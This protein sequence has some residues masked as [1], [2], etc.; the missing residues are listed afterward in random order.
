[1]TAHKAGARYSAGDA[2]S[3]RHRPFLDLVYCCPRQSQEM[4]CRFLLHGLSRRLSEERSDAF[5]VVQ[6]VQFVSQSCL[7]NLRPQLDEGF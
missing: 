3:K 2:W 7:Q 5:S 1:M 6:V 4:P